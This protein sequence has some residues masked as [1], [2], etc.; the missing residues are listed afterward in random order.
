MLVS[1]PVLL[2]LIHVSV[3]HLNH[4]AKII[5]TQG[6]LLFTNNGELANRLMHP[7]SEID[8]EYAVRILGE[9]SEDNLALLKKG[10]QLEDGLA[11][12]DDDF[13]HPAS[14]QMLVSRPVLLVLIHVSVW[15]LNH[16]AKIS[17]H[18]VPA[19]NG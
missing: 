19:L 15:H 6:L 14:Q 12:F 13:F 18:N 8:R 4:R 16:R 11:K 3:W 5:N 17:A 10:V 2:V 9:V 7:S 1:R